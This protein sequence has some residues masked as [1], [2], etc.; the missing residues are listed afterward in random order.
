MSAQKIKETPS[1]RDQLEKRIFSKTDIPIMVYLAV[2]LAIGMCW[3]FRAYN[4]L[5]VDFMIELLGAAFTLFI[6]DVLLVRSKNKRWKI[7]QDDIDYL[8]SRGI[9]RLRDGLATRVFQFQPDVNL[10]VF[11]QRREFLESLEHLTAASLHEKFN[12]LELFS[13]E[14]YAYFNERADDLWSILNM[15][16]SEYLPPVLVSQLITLHVSLKDLGAHIRQF[17]KAD[18]FLDDKE[19]YQSKARA[20]MADSLSAV[21]I[22]VN[23][24]QRE[25]YSEPARNLVAHTAA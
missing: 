8:I 7:V 15:K 14:T 5:F 25:G 18:R 2:F 4:D 20:G 1:L 10:D 17:R 24:L 22:L 12:E 3:A 16:Y 19:Y 21:L 13:S 11:I 9:N 6:I 23:T